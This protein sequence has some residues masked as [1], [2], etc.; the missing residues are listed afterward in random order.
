VSGG[1]VR[2]GLTG[3]DIIGHP[4]FPLDFESAMATNGSDN[5]VPTSDTPTTQPTAVGSNNASPPTAGAPYVAPDGW[6]PFRSLWGLLGYGRRGTLR[7]RHLFTLVFKLILGIGQASHARRSGNWPYAD[8]YNPHQIAA[9]AVLSAISLRTKSP[10]H[11]EQTEWDACDRPL[12]A[13]VMVWLVR[14]VLG[15]VISIYSYTLINPGYVTLRRLLSW[16]LH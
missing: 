12:G 15:I 2:G 3:A 1:T 9:I 8:I 6:H 10:T 16:E 13:W 7:R 4:F 11:P 5:P 14:V